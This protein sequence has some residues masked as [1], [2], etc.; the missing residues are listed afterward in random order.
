MLTSV[1]VLLV[2]NQQQDK[3]KALEYLLQLKEV[4]SFR[5][6][7]YRDLISQVTFE[8][9]IEAEAEATTTPTGIYCYYY[10]Y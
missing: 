3:K 7:Y 5:I 6:N 9:E 10:Y 2:L 8:I 1:Y 4:D